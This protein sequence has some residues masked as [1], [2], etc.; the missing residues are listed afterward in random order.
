M[1]SFLSAADEKNEMLA[2]GRIK[3]DMEKNKLCIK[4]KRIPADV[5]A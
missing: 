2:G 5:I 4:N 1:N 3:T